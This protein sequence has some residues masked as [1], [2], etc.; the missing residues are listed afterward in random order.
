MVINQPPLDKCSL[1]NHFGASSS[2]HFINKNEEIKMQVAIFFV[3]LPCTAVRNDSAHAVQ[4]CVS[5]VG[6]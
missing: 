3:L 2:I 4:Y 5:Y 1:R 6:V